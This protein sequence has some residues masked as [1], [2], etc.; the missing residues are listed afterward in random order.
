V[1]GVRE[2]GYRS[3]HWGL[4]GMRERARSIGARLDIDSVAGAGTTIRLTVPR[5]YRGARPRW[6]AWWPERW[7][8]GN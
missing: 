7:H 2:Q 3:G 6:V 1:N 4:L 5:A 8:S